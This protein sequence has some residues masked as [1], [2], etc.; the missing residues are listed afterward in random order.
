[1]SKKRILITGGAGFIGSNL[2]NRLLDEGHHVIVYDN[3]SRAGAE[4]NMEWLLAHHDKHCEVIVAD[5]RD[6]D[7]LK[8]AVV[9]VDTIYHLAAQVAATTSIASPLDDFAINAFG[10]VNLLEAVRTTTPSAVVV[11]TST[12]KVYG[13]IKD[14]T[15]VEEDSR[16][17]YKYYC[18]EISEDQSLDFHSPYGCSKGAADQYVRDYARIYGLKTVVFRMS[19][20]YGPRQYG[21]ED[22][23]WIAHFA[24]STY[25]DRPVTIYGDGKQVRDILYIDDLVAAFNMVVEHIETTQ[26]QIYNIGG[27][28]ENAISILELIG[29][30][31]GLFDKKINYSFADWRQGDQKVYISDISKALHGFRWRP[32]VCVKYGITRLVEWVQSAD[33]FAEEKF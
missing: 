12:N 22:Q 13:A 29:M 16:Y 24:I 7:M 10:T 27:G 14:K 26:G 33:G 21:I 28:W 8:T 20:I 17:S 32:Q 2:S 25:L 3:L 9:G 19:C 1:M 18:Q 11:Y 31:Q 6:Y 15:I 30:L 5:I 4:K 23:G